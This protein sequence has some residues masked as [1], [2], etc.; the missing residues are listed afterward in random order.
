MTLISSVFASITV[1]DNLQF[2]STDATV[3]V[4]FDESI[5]LDSITV[6]TSQVTLTNMNI[7]GCDNLFTKTYSTAGTYYTSALSDSDCEIGETGGGGSGGSS[8]IPTPTSTTDD[9]FCEIYLSPKSIKITKDNLIEDLKI[10]NEE[11]KSIYP[12]IEFTYQEGNE[13]LF[14]SLTLTNSI[15]TILAGEEYIT[16]LRATKTTIQE[17]S[18]GLLTL[19]V[20]GCDDIE[21]P[22]EIDYE[23][24]TTRQE[25]IETIQ[26][27]LTSTDNIKEEIKDLKDMSFFKSS[28]TDPFYIKLLDKVFSVI[29]L[30][31]IAGLI[32]LIVVYRLDS[33]NYWGGGPILDFIMRIGFTSTITIVIGLIIWIIYIIFN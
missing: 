15:P 8:Y 11:S 6:D 13:Q 9:T 2:Q 28:E 20:A 12:N 30:T 27:T 7:A 29:G 26:D 1:G 19:K 21:I 24:K 31:I 10:T 22:I 4:I 18:E 3:T 33:N 17:T 32:S 14:N 16:G 5:T 25:V 23:N